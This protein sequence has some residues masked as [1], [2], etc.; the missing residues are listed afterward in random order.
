MPVRPNPVGAAPV[1]FLGVVF[2]WAPTPPPG[3]LPPKPIVLNSWQLNPTTDLT[4]S[5]QVLPSPAASYGAVTVKVT[6]ASGSNAQQFELQRLWP[7]P[8]PN[9]AGGR[10]NLR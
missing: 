8:T 10:F 9:L 6:A 1:S 4:G 3:S 7:V 2:R 5:A